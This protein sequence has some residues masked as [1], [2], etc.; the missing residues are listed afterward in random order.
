[1]IK[2]VVI[3]LLLPFSILAGNAF[4]VDY[5]EYTTEELANMRGT[6]QDAS[7]E[8][9]D[10]FRAEW[11]ERLQDMAPE[12]RQKYSGRPDNAQSQ[13]REGRVQGSGNAQGR[14][15][16]GKGAGRGLG[17]GSGKGRQG[18]RR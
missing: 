10:A 15:G 7:P 1:M 5:S 8:E 12:E 9:R 16:Y 11:Q 2:I 18:G 6:L 17:R 3:V 4:A 14:G 13:P